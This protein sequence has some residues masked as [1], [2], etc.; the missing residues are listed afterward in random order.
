M[1]QQTNLKANG[2]MNV[3]ILSVSSNARRMNWTNVTIKLYDDTTGNYEYMTPTI[4]G[5]VSYV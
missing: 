3:E 5:T 1:N 2:L 4:R